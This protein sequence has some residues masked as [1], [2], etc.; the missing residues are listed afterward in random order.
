MYWPMAF[1]SAHGL[2]IAPPKWCNAI[3]KDWHPRAERYMPAEHNACSLRAMR[4]AGASTSARP[5]SDKPYSNAPQLCR[6]HLRSFETLFKGPC[7]AWPAGVH[8]THQRHTMHGPTTV[9]G[10]DASAPWGSAHSCMPPRY[11]PEAGTQV[12]AVSHAKRRL[13]AGGLPPA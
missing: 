6:E 7:L 1:A 8:L 12:S 11:V 9:L 4:E 13:V 2:R 5:L 3:Y 10:S